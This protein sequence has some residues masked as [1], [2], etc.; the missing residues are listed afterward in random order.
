MI[1]A[2]MRKTF[3]TGLLVIIP[4]ALTIFIAIKL[5]HFFDGILGQYVSTFL[6]H[7]LK[8]P[9]IKTPIPGLGLLF[10][11]ALVFLAG[12]IARNYFGSR[13]I[14]LGDYIVTHIPLMNR[15]YVA[16]REIS[17]AFLSEKREVFKKAVLVEYPRKGMYSVGFFTQDTKGPIQDNLKEDVVSIFLPTSPNPTSGYLLFVPKSQVTDL[18][19]PVEDALKLVISAGSVQL[20]DKKMP[21]PSLR[22]K[23]KKIH[24]KEFPGRHRD[25]SL[26]EDSVRKI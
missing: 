6:S 21:F 17:E 24:V 18:D 25:E 2:Q 15:I 12:T 7:D 23:R 4:L 10:L 22:K 20:N 5:F 9:G 1:L 13:L 16:I 3:V 26:P 11:V 19:M 14:A 8:V